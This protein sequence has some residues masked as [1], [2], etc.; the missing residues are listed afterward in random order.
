MDRHK[1]WLHAGLPPCHNDRGAAV[2]QNC[3]TKDRQYAMMHKYDGAFSSRNLRIA[4]G[5]VVSKPS[6]VVSLVDDDPSVLRGLARLL[7]IEGYETRQF[8]TPRL[9]LDQYDPNVP[10]CII[11]D[12]AMPDLSGLDLQQLIGS[13][14]DSLP[15]IF[16]SGHGDVPISVAAMKRGALDFFTKPVDGTVLLTAVRE[17]IAMDAA[18]RKSRA[19]LEEVEQ[20]LERLSPRERTVF[21]QVVAGRLNKQIAG[22]LGIA[23][24]TVKVHRARL[25]KKMG[26]RSFA[27]LMKLAHRL[28]TA[29]Q[30][31]WFSDHRPNRA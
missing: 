13:S 18:T 25:M 5:S 29:S 21:A 22:S 24:K 2:H 3:T 11:L 6:P 12:V 17:A 8:A 28:E 9:F 15:I 4:G 7:A 10:G 1:S 26:V 16:L 23:E 14:K 20:R 30:S 27:E 19:A 31:R